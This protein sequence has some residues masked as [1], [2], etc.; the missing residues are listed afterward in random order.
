[1]RE[2]FPFT[3]RRKALEVL[4]RG[5]SKSRSAGTNYATQMNQRFLINLFAE[6]KF[7]VIAEVAQKPAKTPKGALAAVNASRKGSIAI[8]FRFQNPE[9]DSQ[10]GFCGW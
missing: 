3:G 5:T 6:Q 8:R 2:R 1:M 9:A 7:R 4:V 10:E